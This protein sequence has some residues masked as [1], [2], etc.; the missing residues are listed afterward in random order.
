MGGQKKFYQRWMSITEKTKLINEC[1]LVTNVFSSLN[2]IIKSVADNALGNHKDSQIKTDALN[3]LF[4]N[5]HIGLR[6]SLKRWREYNQMRKLI[7]RMDQT[8]KEM[9]LKVLTNILYQGKEGKI[10]EAINK[11]RQNRKIVDI[12]RNFLKRLMM[13]KA[14][15]VVIGF[16][17][18]KALPVR[19]TDTN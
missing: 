16:K 11:F 12:Q 8:K 3:K 7:D 15:M 14:G 18:W 6:D 5:V 9:C 17:T 10:R 4:A 19:P 13:S 2:F 1:K